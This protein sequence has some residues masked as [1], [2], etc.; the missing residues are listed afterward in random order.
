MFPPGPKP[1][2]GGGG[3]WPPPLG[4]P[5]GLHPPSFFFLLLLRLGGGGLELP[6]PEGVAAAGGEFP[7]VVV[8]APYRPSPL[9]MELFRHWTTFLQVINELELKPYS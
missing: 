9:R 5:A 4:P 6:S 7:P 2:G 3:G 1:G 8:L